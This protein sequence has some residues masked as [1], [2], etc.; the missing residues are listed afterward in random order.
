[1][2]LDKIMFNTDIDIDVFIP[3]SSNSMLAIT[4][5]TAYKIFFRAL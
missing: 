5:D 4:K 2:E 1:M 3:Y